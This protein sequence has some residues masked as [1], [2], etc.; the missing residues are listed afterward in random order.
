MVN[1][2]YTDADLV[3]RVTDD[4]GLPAGL[5]TA[6]IAA[7]G[8]GHGIIGMRERVHLCGGTFE[9]GPLPDGGFAVAAALPLPAAGAP[10]WGDGAATGGGAGVAPDTGAV[11]ATGA[12][13]PQDAFAVAGDGSGE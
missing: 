13:F 11:R 1:L 10:A 12:G 9:A 6:G 3:I 8:T 2:C 7:A 4:G 5:G